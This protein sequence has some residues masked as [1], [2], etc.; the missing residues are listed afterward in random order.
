MFLEDISSTPEAVLQMI[1][2]NCRTDKPCSKKIFAV[3]NM[4]YHAGNF[5]IVTA[6]YV[7]MCGH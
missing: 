4:R 7:T 6:I 1:C 2:C 3:Y 5:V